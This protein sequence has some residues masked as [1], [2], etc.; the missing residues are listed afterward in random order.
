MPPTRYKTFIVLYTFSELK[1]T[2]LPLDKNAHFG[3]VTVSLTRH[4]RI[5]YSAQPYRLLGTVDSKSGSFCD[6][7]QLN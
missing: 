1:K 2:A 3:G 5:A 4:N 6:C 7:L